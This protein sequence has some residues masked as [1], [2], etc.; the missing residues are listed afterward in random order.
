MVFY[1]GSTSPLYRFNQPSKLVVCYTGSTSS[2]YWWSD[3]QVQPALYTGGLLHRFN[4]P[5]I[6]V[7]CYTG[8]TSPSYS[9]SVTQVQ[10]A[11]LYCW[12]VT[13]V[14]PALYTRGLSH[15]LTQT[16]PSIPT[17]VTAY[18][19]WKFLRYWHRLK[20]GINT[21]TSNPCIP[22]SWNVKHSAYGTFQSLEWMDGWMDGWMG[23]WGM[24][25]L[26]WG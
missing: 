12:S 22:S 17:T 18:R 1:T 6:L 9:W 15:R 14:Q 7:V 26:K 3:T 4:Q 19:A 20:S 11:L 5:F 10:P 21:E 8:S 24:F 23:I 25:Q 2:L 13:Q 16:I